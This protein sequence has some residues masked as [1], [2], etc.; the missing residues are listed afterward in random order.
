MNRRHILIL[1]QKNFRIKNNVLD[2]FLNKKRKMKLR[3]IYIYTLSRGRDMKNPPV[4]Y[5]FVLVNH[6]QSNYSYPSTVKWSTWHENRKKI[7]LYPFT[8]CH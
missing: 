6:I 3:N 5:L 4:A 8:S 7:F 1:F 2:L